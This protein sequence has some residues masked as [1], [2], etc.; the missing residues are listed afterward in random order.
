MRLEQ[1]RENQMQEVVVVV[2]GE[3]VNIVRNLDIAC[4]PKHSCDQEEIHIRRLHTSHG[5]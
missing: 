3:N 2:V 5:S 1:R 4:S